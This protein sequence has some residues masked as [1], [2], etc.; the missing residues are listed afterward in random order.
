MKLTAVTA[1]LEEK[2]LGLDHL[3]ALEDLLVVASQREWL[4]IT[5][6]GFRSHTNIE[7]EA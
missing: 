1:A 7:I 4:P 2:D 5:K 3:E 6:H